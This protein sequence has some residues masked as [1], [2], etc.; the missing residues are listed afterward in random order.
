MEQARRLGDRPLE[1]RLLNNLGIYT[2]APEETYQLIQRYLAIGEE[3]GDLRAQRTAHANLAELLLRFGR[4]DEAQE[5]AERTIALSDSLNDPHSRA[6][7]IIQRGRAWQARGAYGPARADITRGLGLLQT[8]GARLSI[9][10][11]LLELSRLML[12]EGQPRPALANIEQSYQL[13]LGLNKP[14]GN[15]FASLFHAMQ[16]QAQLGLRRNS[17]ARSLVHAALAALDDA[18]APELAGW[19]DTSIEVLARC[20]RVLA[21]VGPDNEATALL[22]RAHAQLEIVAARCG[23]TL[24]Q[25]YLE[26]LA[27]CRVIRAAW[28]T[29]EQG[30]DKTANAAA[31]K[32]IKVSLRQEQIIVLLDDAQKRGDTL[33]EEDL[34]RQFGVDKRTIQRDLAQLH[35]QGRLP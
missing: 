21:K 32:S 17:H 18:S 3:I 7:A 14:Y 6:E 29:H 25:S 13:W 28:A 22:E 15:R 30:R 9:M 24:R 34:A 26:N 33:N 19:V 10:W 12:E 1:A 16:A 4:Y 8:L 11:G 20:Y 2:K 27:E 23:P 31:G 35:K 5:H